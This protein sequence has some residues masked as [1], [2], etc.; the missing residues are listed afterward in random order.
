MKYA[1]TSLTDDDDDDDDIY[2]HGRLLL[3]YLE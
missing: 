1:T 3:P 2:M